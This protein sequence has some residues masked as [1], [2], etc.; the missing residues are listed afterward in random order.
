ML[1]LVVGAEKEKASRPLSSQLKTRNTV[2]S[3]RKRSGLSK[4]ELDR[5]YQW[6]RGNIRGEITISN[7]FTIMGGYG[8]FGT[9]FGYHLA[10]RSSGFRRSSIYVPVRMVAGILL[11]AQSD[12]V[13]NINELIY[14]NNILCSSSGA[15][16][17]IYLSKIPETKY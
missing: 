6:E 8:R 12:T 3:L 14:M 13:A 1:R 16:L 2:L 7:G 5:C 4:R 17:S 11:S 10:G 9:R 15:T